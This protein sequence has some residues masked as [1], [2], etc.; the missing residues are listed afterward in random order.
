[1]TVAELYP[2]CDQNRVLFLQQM[3]RNYSFESSVQIQT[4]RE[5]LDQLQRENSDLKQMII[6]NELNKNALEK[7]NKMFEQTL[8]QK[9]Q[10][11]KQLFET[12]DKL[13]KTET[14]LRILKETYLPFENQGAQIP[15]LSLTQIQ[16]EKENTREQMKMEVAA[17]NA[18]IEGLELLKSQISKSEFIAQECYREM[19]KIRD[20]E[21]R[22]EETLLISKVKCEK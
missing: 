9:E 6:E 1:M 14:E 8:Q 22:E 11:K 21:D 2:P 12:E 17:Q 5:H 13:F 4:L 18:N 3:N 15:K 7:Q 10:L 19:K 20:R 16:K